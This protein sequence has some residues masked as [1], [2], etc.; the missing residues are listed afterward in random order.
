MV[1]L[2]SYRRVDENPSTPT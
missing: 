1:D 2:Q